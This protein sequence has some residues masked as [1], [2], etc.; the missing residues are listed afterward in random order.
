[1]TRKTVTLTG[2]TGNMLRA[3]DYGG[4]GQ[5]VLMFHGGGQTRF[6]WGRT[7]SRLSAAGFRAI[8]VDQRGHGDSAWVD[9]GDYRFASYG[10][11]VITLASGQGG[12]AFDRKPILI[13]ASLGGIAGLFAE[14]SHPGLLAMLVL[15]D[16]VPMM[17]SAGVKGLL[18]MSGF[19][20]SC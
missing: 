4:D 5:P 18:I 1:M 13:G 20:K 9:D 15:V 14:I 2:S 12:L 8:T 17:D 3:D 19:G 11:D 16:I 6:A 10:R 7:A